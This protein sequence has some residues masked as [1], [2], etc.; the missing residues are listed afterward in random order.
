MKRTAIGTYR[1]TVEIQHPSNTPNAYGEPVKT[2]TTAATV[3]AEVRGLN[4]REL[5]HQ[6]QIKATLSDSVSM[7]WIDESD[8]TRPTPESRI[9]HGTRNLYVSAVYDPTGE[10]VELRCLCSEDAA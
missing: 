9:K 7:R 2:W 10:S 6:A 3:W 1:H 4:G 8:P 5:L